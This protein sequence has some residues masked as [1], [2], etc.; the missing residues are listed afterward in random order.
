MILKDKLNGLSFLF[1]YP[2][3][4]DID[5]Y[6]IGVIL[7]NAL[8]NAIEATRLLDRNKYISLNF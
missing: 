4:F 6:D 2:K 7:N 5:L 1:K 3:D 8:E